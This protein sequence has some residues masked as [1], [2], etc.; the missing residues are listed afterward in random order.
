MYR[1]ALFVQ[2]YHLDVMASEPF[3]NL[4]GASICFAIQGVG[5]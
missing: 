5:I 1:I 4:I 2:K 3:V